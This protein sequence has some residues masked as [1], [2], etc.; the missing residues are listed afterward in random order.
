MY[1][2]YFPVSPREFYALST[3]TTLND[4]DATLICSSALPD[5]FFPPNLSYVRAHVLMSA[6]LLIPVS[7][8]ETDVIMLNH[9]H[10][11]ANVPAYIMNKAS[12]NIPVQ[13][14]KSLRK[15]V[16]P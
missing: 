4:I 8:L 1:K 12:V 7:K 15:Y 10:V 14:A 5:E 2:A 6:F 9:S 16:G 11:A 3:W 13:Y